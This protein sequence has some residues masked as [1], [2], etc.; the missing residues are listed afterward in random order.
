MLTVRQIIETLG[1]D[2]AAHFLLGKCVVGYDGT[3]PPE[4][5]CHFP[6]VELY[7]KGRII[8]PATRRGEGG[9]D[10]WE[11]DIIDVNLLDILALTDGDDFDVDP[12]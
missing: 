10:L 7:R 8:I 11:S 12:R 9:A 2:A 3:S 5:L 4:R 1:E 6:L